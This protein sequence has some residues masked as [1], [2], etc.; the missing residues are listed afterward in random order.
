MVQTHRTH[1]PLSTRWMVRPLARQFYEDTL[2]T[3][4]NGSVP[5]LLGGA[6][7]LKHFAGIARD[8]KDLDVFLRKRDLEH[9]MAA[10]ADIGFETEVA[11][12]H[13]LAKAWSGPHFVDLIFDSANGLCPVD[14]AWFEN[15]EGC[16]LWNIPV[17]LSPVEEMIMSKCFV[18]ERE[19]FDGADVYHLLEAC[20]PTLD[21]DRL[22]RRFGENWR[23]LLGHLVFFSFV[24]PQRR[25]CIPVRLMNDLLERAKRE[26]RPEDVEVCRGTLLSR[27]QYLVDLRER[28]YAD[29]RVAPWGGISPED[30]QR[31]TEGIRT[32]R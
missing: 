29:A 15:A 5:F 13:W 10:L 26:M 12:P 17:L 1:L 3:L 28:G 8:T 14:D 7:A 22:V 31:W 20:G 16:T 21:W 11:Y 2:R 30:I 4:T 23:V 18:M 24:Y 25:H 6:I 27:E 9:A 19:R 32:G